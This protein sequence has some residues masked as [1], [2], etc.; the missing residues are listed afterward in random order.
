MTPALRHGV[1]APSSVTIPINFAWPGGA[2]HGE[3]LSSFGSRANVSPSQ[4]WV[5]APSYAEVAA[6]YP[7]AAAPPVPSAK[8]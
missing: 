7:P 3:L 5:D 8:P 1:P 4:A 6:A 2:P